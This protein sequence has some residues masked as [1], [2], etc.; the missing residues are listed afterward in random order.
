[1]A[2][3]SPVERTAAIYH[4]EPRRRSPPLADG[5][6]GDA[7]LLRF[8]SRAEAEALRRRRQPR[9]G[10]ECPATPEFQNGVLGLV[11][12]VVQSNVRT[13]EA[14]FRFAGSGGLIELQQHV[15]GEYI[16]AVIKSDVALW[17][18]MRRLVGGR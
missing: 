8:P 11:E 4:F 7:E 10:R 15:A 14:M 12:A 17:Q 16:A 3:Y 18:A 2:T 13:M 5:G 1:M 6:L 9:E